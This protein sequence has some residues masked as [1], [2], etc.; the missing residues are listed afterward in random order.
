MY[1]YIIPG[2]FKVGFGITGNVQDREKGYTG[3]WGSPAR[4]SDVWQGSTAMVKTLEDTIKRQHQHLLYKIDDDWVTEWFDN[5]WEH[6][7]V[8]QFVQQL[9]AGMHLQLH[10]IV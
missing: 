7:D 6:R 9:I 8:Q 2:P 1:F 5:G 10:K 3:H 4:F